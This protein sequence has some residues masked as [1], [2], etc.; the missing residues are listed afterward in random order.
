MERFFTRDNKMGTAPVSRLLL[1]MSLPLMLSM[2]MEALYN[3]VDSL[4]ISRIG[5]NAIT[6]LSLAFPI[7]LLVVSITVGTGVGINAVLSRLLGEGD[8]RGVNA[9]A[10]NGIFLA[11]ATYVIFLLFGLFCTERYYGSQTA[12]AEIYRYGVDYLSICMIWSFGGVG[13]ITFQRLLQST[14]RTALSMASQLAGALI[15]IVLDP[16]LIFGLCGAPACGVKGAA[17]ATV[18]GQITALAA[19][20]YFNLR[21]NRDISFKLR[22]FRPDFNM[23]KK[24]YAIGAP[25]IVMQSLNSLMAL[26]V[27]LILIGLSSTAVA[28]FGIYIKVQNFVF[29]PAFGLNN[30]V[31]AV[32]AFNYGAGN[33]P[34][35]RQT[36]RYGMIY[37]AAIMLAGMFLVQLL[38]LPILRLF[39]ASAELLSIGGRA[40]RVVSAGYIFTAYMLIAQGACQALGNGLYSL[41]VTLLRVVVVLLP[42]LWLFSVVFPLNEVWWAFVISEIISMLVSALLLRRLYA[43]RLGAG[44]CL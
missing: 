20:V 39:D 27:N 18:I 34:R 9:A 42:L 40:M 5:E 28:A 12:D 44:G 14:G 3:V 16:I 7:Q 32:A 29:M 31:I 4:F 11:A 24:I 10:A 43:E 37:A 2:V 23:I 25:A 22:G 21:M 26:G 17:A 36:I 35:V 33:E 13:Q 30:A 6:A 41:I 19:A 8:R 15:N 38:A 1:T